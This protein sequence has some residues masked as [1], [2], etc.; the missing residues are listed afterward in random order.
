M[1]RSS[2]LL[3]NI[4]GMI[5]ILLLVL[6]A[7]Q[8]L[9]PLDLLQGARVYEEKLTLDNGLLTGEIFHFNA[10]SAETLKVMSVGQSM[11]V[12]PILPGRTALSLRVYEFIY[13][14]IALPIIHDFQ[15]SIVY[16][17]LNLSRIP[18]RAKI[19][20]TKF[21]Y[22]IQQ[23]VRE[24][25]AT[26]FTLII[27]AH[28]IPIKQY[29]S[30]TPSA[31]R[32]QGFS[33]SDFVEATEKARNLTAVLPLQLPKNS[34]AAVASMGVEPLYILQNCLGRQAHLALIPSAPSLESFL[35][36]PPPDIHI[37]GE[38]MKFFAAQADAQMV[39]SDY[40]F[41][42]SYVLYEGSIID[43]T[44][45]ATT[46]TTVNVVWSPSP[47]RPAILTEPTIGT[48]VKADWPLVAAIL[49]MILFAILRRPSP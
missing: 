11:D 16:F 27:S 45:S 15:Q 1:K 29:S 4:L 25:G 30:F 44:T 23:Y 31:D 42:I 40:Y 21:H 2:R 46:S 26:S 5:A 22:V 17:R 14:A 48:P 3:P 18:P 12:E 6:Y 49:L 28:P 35:P 34:G 19:L 43:S 32:L 10:R 33:F 9:N 47:P 38:G 13:P 20:N 24:K 39:I 36:P 7:I 8:P 41:T 37:G